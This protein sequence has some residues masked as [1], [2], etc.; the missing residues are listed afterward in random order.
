M[1][2]RAFAKSPGIAPYIPFNLFGGQVQGVVCLG[3]AVILMLATAISPR[4]FEGKRTALKGALAPV[5]STFSAPFIG[6]SEG[7]D[8]LFQLSHL[9]TEVEKLRAENKR[10]EEWYNTAQ[11]LQAE[12]Q[13]LRDLMKVKL[14]PA[15]TFV[16]TRVIGDTGGPYAQTII[17]GAGT[18]EGV[19]KGDAVLGGEGLIG[20]VTDVAANAST[21]LL[22]TDLNSRIPIR[23]EGSN[24]QAI[25]AGTNGQ[26]LGIE[27]VPDGSSLNDDLRV[28][29][30]GIG[31]VFPPDIPIGTV[32][33]AANGTLVLKPYA[34][35]ARLLFV[36]IVRV[37][38][39]PANMVVPEQP[40]EAPAPAP[41]AAGVKK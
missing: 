22:I 41:K 23:I 11:L 33:N 2:R 28:L 1:R 31:G 37:P 5:L 15:L 35:F 12:N 30:S 25:L 14:D 21:V 4:L 38:A 36:R 20:R 10:L 24:I 27:R 18:D 29:T 34:D 17:V 19:H 32:K 9:K 7:L 40:K 13:S 8:Y 26:R 16:T 39:R 6:L 3:L